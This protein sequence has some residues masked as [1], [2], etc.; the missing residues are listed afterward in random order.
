MIR[1]DIVW[2]ARAATCIMIGLAMP[3]SLL[4]ETQSARYEWSEHRGIALLFQ[5]SGVEGTFVSC[6][7]P[8]GMLVGHNAERALKRL[9]PASTFKIPHTLIALS[10]GAVEGIDEEFEWDG[11]R[12]TFSSWERDMTLAEAF[13]T[14]NLFVYREVAARVGMDALAQSLR[15]MDY[16]NRDVGEDLTNFW[17]TGPLKI[18][19]LE[20]CRFLLRLA[21]GDL[22]IEPAHVQKLRT[23]MARDMGGGVTLFAKTGWATAPEP[24]P[25]WW[26]G[27]VE[28]PFGTAAFA[29]SID[30][31]DPAM[32]AQ[33]VELGTRAL[34]ELGL[35]PKALSD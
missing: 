11:N 20:Q 26:V 15:A 30:M 18:S 25:G 6:R 21:A 29:L 3:V 2:P 14:S 22:P 31:P 4:A 1:V 13:E 19:A 8:D 9:A 5:G 7:R 10:V 23:L 33:R 34:Q 17:L 27:W 35:L 24:G 16:G 32:A 28:G 12:R